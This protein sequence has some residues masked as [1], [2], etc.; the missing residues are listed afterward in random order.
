[1]KNDEKVGALNWRDFRIKQ[2]PE[3]PGRPTL[4][5]VVNELKTLPVLV[6][7]KEILSLQEQLYEVANGKAILLQCGDFAESFAG[8]NEN[9]VRDT[10]RVILQMALLF[11]LETKKLW[12]ISILCKRKIQKS[13]EFQDY[14]NHFHSFEKGSL[15]LE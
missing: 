8:Y 7:V 14:V 15:I 4:A 5:R 3:Y 1:M 10:L 11:S 9:T 12:L 6:P 2:L 13:R